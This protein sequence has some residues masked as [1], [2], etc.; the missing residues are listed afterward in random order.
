M[1]VD[2]LNSTSQPSSHHIQRRS[3][4]KMV[5]AG[6]AASIPVAAGLLKPLRVLAG[7]PCVNKLCIDTQQDDT[8]CVEGVWIEGDKY[9]CWDALTGE[10]CNY[11][12]RNLHVIGCC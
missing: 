6:L 11:E 3:F 7:I 8:V 5:V 2:R 12:L 10:F 1:S 9:A 4:L